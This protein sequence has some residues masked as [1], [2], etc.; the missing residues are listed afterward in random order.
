METPS[1]PDLRPPGRLLTPAAGKTQPQ[2]P[3]DPR[4]PAAVSP[5]ARSIPPPVMGALVLQPTLLPL[6]PLLPCPPWWSQPALLL[7]PALLPLAAPT[8][9]PEFV[10][11][12][13]PTDIQPRRRPG[14]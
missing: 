8:P 13:R 6:L 10:G 5:P 1:R 7:L 3:I 11:E 2:S 4:S 9:R 12:R 14:V